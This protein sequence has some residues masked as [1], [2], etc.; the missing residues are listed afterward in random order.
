MP[1]TII[2]SKWIKY[3]TVKLEPIKNLKKKTG[4]KTLDIFHSYIFSNTSPQTRETKENIMKCDYIKLKSFC[5]SKAH[6]QQDKKGT[7]WM[8]EHICQWY[9]R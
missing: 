2:N 7:H 4:N 1:H 9:I 8:G 6:L 3:L 5:T